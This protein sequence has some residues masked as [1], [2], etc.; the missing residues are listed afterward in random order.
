MC[1][2]LCTV[3]CA[4]AQD[5]SRIEKLLTEADGLIEMNKLD[6][7]LGKTQE[8][9]K[10]NPSDLAALQKRIDIYYLM[11]DDKEALNFTE[12]AIR[13]YPEDAELYYLRGIIN[14][15]REKYAK[16][17]SDFNEALEWAN[18]SIAYKIYLG[19]GISQM[20]LME[21]EQA[22]ADFSKSIALNDTVASAYHSRA[23]LNYEIKDYH[24]AI[25][26]FQRALDHSEGTP[27]LYFNMGM[28]YYR[29]DDLT[30]ACPYFHRACTMGNTNACRMALME[31]A[32]E[33]PNIP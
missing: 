26:D 19:R 31:C 20:N 6:Q 5:G 27:V 24:A 33:I 28:A 25:D 21:Y 32:K 15:T 22:M 7:A 17:L 8:A 11:N 14:N 4:F 18:D 3:M 2:L 13:Q 1:A 30:N 29:L 12:M 23:L 16:A 10:I 9:L